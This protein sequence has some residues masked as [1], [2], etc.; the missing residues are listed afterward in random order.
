M[1]SQVVSALL[2]GSAVVAFCAIGPR[3]DNAHGA[4]TDHGAQKGSAASAGDAPH[5]KEKGGHGG[6]NINPVAL[7]E[8]QADLAIWTAVVFLV[9]MAVL[10]KF[11][12]GPLTKG[13]E[14][15]EKRIADEIA[16]AERSNVEARQLLEEYEQRL[17]ATGQEVQE[18]L[19][20]ARRDAEQAGHEIVEKARA[21]A[22][23]EHQRALGEIELA[24]AG[25]LKELAEQ[26]ATLAVGLAGKIVR[27]E[28]D[29]KAHSQLIA[30]AMADFSRESG[31]NGGSRGK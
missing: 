22:R 21:E 18:M 4:D 29:P 16:S 20:A 10:W 27:S 26:S 19:Q 2:F 8:L 12:W 7:E 17:A 6:G 13:L 15:R 11:A 14:K 30:Q 28:L 9:L 23:I 3:V 24:T 31:G 1:R 5:G 25:A